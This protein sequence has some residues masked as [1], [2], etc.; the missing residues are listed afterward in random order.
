MKVESDYA[1]KADLKNTTG[2]DTSNLVKRSDIANLKS[3]VDIEHYCK[4]R[5]NQY[6]ID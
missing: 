2:V 1:A 6:C 4:I 5:K 3:E